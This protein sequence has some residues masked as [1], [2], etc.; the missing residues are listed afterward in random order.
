M[1]NKVVR[2]GLYFVVLGVALRGFYSD[3]GVVWLIILTIGGVIFIMAEWR[4]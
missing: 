3:D 1:K 2:L 4:T